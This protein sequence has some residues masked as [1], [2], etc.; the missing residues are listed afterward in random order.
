[1]NIARTAHRILA[2]SVAFALVAALLA[3]DE[4]TDK[5]DKLFASWDKTTSPG[6]TLAV[7]RDGRI[8]CKHGYGMA[9]IEDGI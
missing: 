4:T 3:A 7:V 5:V 1:M 8:V 2:I 9:K 6:A